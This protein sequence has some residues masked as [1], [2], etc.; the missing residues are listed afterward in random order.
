MLKGAREPIKQQTV[1]GKDGG[2][3]KQ[4]ECVHPRDAAFMKGLPQNQGEEAPCVDVGP[5]LCE[6]GKAP[7][8]SRGDSHPDGPGRAG[9]P[10][11]F[12]QDES[13]DNQT[14]IEGHFDVS[15]NGGGDK[16]V[17]RVENQGHG[18][19]PGHADVTADLES[20]P[21]CERDRGEPLDKPGAN[22]SQ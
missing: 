15:A 4:D 3:S 17:D 19:P 20:D 7:D 21:I 14:S 13:Q 6:R 22:A 2:K 10:G 9:P 8:N 16:P 11:G 5:F 1:E 18:G 12:N